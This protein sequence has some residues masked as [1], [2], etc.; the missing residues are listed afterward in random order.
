MA[1]RPETVRHSDLSID[2]IHEN[3]AGRDSRHL[4]REFVVFVNDGETALDISGWTV[5]DEAGNAFQ[6]PERTE[7]RP[8]ERVRLYS[9][10]GS[11]T[12][13][14]FF[15]RAD[16]PLWRNAGDTVL[17]RDDTGTVRI[18]ETYNE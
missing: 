5:E 18:R 14:E 4:D 6:F 17:V 11:D 1:D 9:G 12:G 15:W 10:E 16:G 13:H 3:P 7:V 8:G 2:E